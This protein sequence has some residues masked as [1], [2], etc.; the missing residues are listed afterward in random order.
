MSKSEIENDEGFCGVEAE[1]LATAQAGIVQAQVSE[2]HQAL[3]LDY[4]PAKLSS[5]AVKAAAQ[6]IGAEAGQSYGRCLLRLDGR[7]CEACALKLE[8][9]TE[10]IPGVRRATATYLGG[11]MT[12]TFDGRELPGERVMDAVRGIGAKVRAYSEAEAGPAWVEMIFTGL[13]LVFLATAFIG[14]K[15]HMSEAL[16]AIFYTGAYFTGG[17]FGV[18]ASIESLKQRTVDVDLLMVLAALGAAGVGAPMEG[19]MLLFLF[20]LSNVLQDF[21]IDRTRKAIRSL[22]QLRP[23]Q[24][25]VKRGAETLMLPIEDV[26]LGDEIVVR[27]GERVPLDGEVIEGRTSIDE[28]SITGESLPVSKSPGGTV[29][30]GTINQTGAIEV[31]VTKLAQDSTIARLIQ[32]VEV[33]QSEKAQTQRWL[34]RAEQYYAMGVIALTI[35][36][37]VVPWLLGAGAFSAIFYRAMTVMV[38]ASPCALVISTPATILSAIGGAARR[39]VLFKGG[40]HLE[41][42]ATIKTVVF[43]KTGTLTEGKPRVTDV[44]GDEADLLALAASV[45]TRSEHPLAQAIVNDARARKL[46]LAPCADFQSVSGQGASGVVNG[47]RIAVGNARYLASFGLPEPVEPF[48][49]E[50]KTAVYVAEITQ[51]PARFLGTIAIA[52][53]LRP[54]AAAAVRALKA[55]GVQ[56]VIM[57]TGDNR[58]VAAAIAKLA[59]VDEF[60]A[61]LRPE[62]KLKLVKQMKEL[63]PVAMVGDGVNDAPALAAATLGIAMGAAGTD[64]AMETADVVLMNNNLSNVAYAIGISRRARRVVIQNLSFALGVIVVLIASALGLHLPL[65]LGVVGHEGSTVLVCLNGLRLLLPV[66][67]M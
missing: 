25:L 30:A 60:H 61:E 44:A 4:D 3:T 29:F 41:T 34:D 50:G 5:T 51:T 21:A 8:R 57:L 2:N 55:Q 40:A 56:R 23:T 26:A 42:A 65:T 19:A 10:K 52:D 31:R 17:W 66:K 24:A 43:D 20:S 37:I 28:A 47:R 6:Q 16:V 13:T 38:V 9:K 11:T 58:H 32:M 14:S 1:A 48:S 49:A 46:A 35:G 63:Q 12:V 22:M 64:V 7:G 18:L 27:P 36:L 45:E 39:G 54:D 33:A 62:D 53:V 15:L 59:G 67:A